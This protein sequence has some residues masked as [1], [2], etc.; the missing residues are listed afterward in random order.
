MPLTD[1]PL[2]AYVGWINT[3][4]NL[5]NGIQETLCCIRE[6]KRSR[7][8]SSPAHAHVLQGTSSHSSRSGAVHLTVLVRITRNEEHAEGKVH[9]EQDAINIG[10]GRMR[11]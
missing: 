7:L 11:T 2:R 5:D 6:G 10:P 1:P 8:T 4:A 9:S 3:L